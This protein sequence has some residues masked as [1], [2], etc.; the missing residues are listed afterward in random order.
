MTGVTGVWRGIGMAAAVLL[1]TASLAGCSHDDT[2]LSQKEPATT[3][4]SGDAGPVGAVVVKLTG[5]S[6]TAQPLGP[7]LGPRYLRLEMEAIGLTSAEADCVGQKADPQVVAAMSLQG[8]DTP[9]GMDPTTMSSCVTPARLAAISS[10]A[11]DFNRVPVADLRAFLK[12]VSTKTMTAAG[13]SATEADCMNS[14]TIDKVSD[15]QLPGMLIPAT[16]TPAAAGASVTTVAPGA[17]TAASSGD[18]AAAVRT[19]LTA[20]RIADL[21]G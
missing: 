14:K 7:D 15:L 20:A 17:V 6:A 5:P 10:G 3:V 21:G 2:I 12:A 4:D 11:P 18:L 13:L 8:G 16:T 9:P 1:A 19:C